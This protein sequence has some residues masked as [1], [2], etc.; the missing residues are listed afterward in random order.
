MNLVASQLSR[1]GGRVV[2]RDGL[3]NRWGASSRG[4]ESLPLRHLRTSMGRDKVS[5]LSP[6]SATRSGIDREDSK[7]GVIKLNWIGKSTALKHRLSFQRI[8]ELRAP[9]IHV[10]LVRVLVPARSSLTGADHCNHQLLGLCLFLR[11]WL[12]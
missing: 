12:V 2:Y 7:R 9:E 5:L 4:F 10:S 3:E 1:R 8:A 11:V 6:A